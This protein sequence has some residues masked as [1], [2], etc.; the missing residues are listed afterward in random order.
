MELRMLRAISLLRDGDA[1]VAQVADQ[2]GFNH[3]GFFNRCF[4]RR[5]GMSPGRWRVVS[6]KAST[7]GAPAHPERER[8]KP[9]DTGAQGMETPSPPPSASSTQLK[10]AALSP[11]LEYLNSPNEELRRHNLPVVPPAMMANL[12][13]SPI[14]GIFS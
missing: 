5:F 13:G 14:L 3:L 2:C 7:L 11:V 4:K 8:G 6:A 12:A 1:K 10:K 9:S